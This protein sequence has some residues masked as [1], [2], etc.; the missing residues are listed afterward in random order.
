MY[1]P[2]E[3]WTIRERDTGKYILSRGK[4]KI[5]KGSIKREKKLK[6]KHK[7]FV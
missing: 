6:L 2:R 4:N 5:Q 7:F 1:S 3:N